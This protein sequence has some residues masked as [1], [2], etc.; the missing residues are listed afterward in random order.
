MGR[1]SGRIRGLRN[2]RVSIASIASSAS[3]PEFS[4]VGLQL[5][6]AIAALLHARSS[7]SSSVTQSAVARRSSS[8]TPRAPI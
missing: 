4:D 8:A 7:P 1:R 2:R 3:R 6:Q 5:G